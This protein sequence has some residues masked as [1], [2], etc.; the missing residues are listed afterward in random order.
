M[1]DEISQ[2]AID[3]LSKVMAEA[4]PEADPIPLLRAQGFEVDPEHDTPRQAKPPD[5][6]GFLTCPYCGFAEPAPFAKVDLYIC[7]NCGRTVETE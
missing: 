7:G 4:E 6:D 2:D 1:S 5:E 3:R